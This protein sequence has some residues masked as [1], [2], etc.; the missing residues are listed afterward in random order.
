MTRDMFDEM[1]ETIGG[2]GLDP[3]RQTKSECKFMNISRLTWA[4][5]A[6]YK[7]RFSLNEVFRDVPSGFETLFL[8]VKGEFSV[9][10]SS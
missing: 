5:C 9:F 2:L 8:Q 7:V 1:L 6:T 3:G 4:R 10:D